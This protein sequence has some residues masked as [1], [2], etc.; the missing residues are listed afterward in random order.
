MVSDRVPTVT[1]FEPTTRV[2][3]IGEL[4][5]NCVSAAEVLSRFRSSSSLRFL[6]NE[7]RSET[8]D[9][10]TGE[11]MLLKRNVQNLKYAFA[12]PLKISLFWR[13]FVAGPEQL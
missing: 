13:G 6:E 11:L 5:P 12:L 3:D 4:S 7:K 9:R 2:S 10:E 1:G 8:Q